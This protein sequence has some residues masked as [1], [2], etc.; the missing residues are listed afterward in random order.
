MYSAKSNQL[1][2]DDGLYA[3]E[4]YYIADYG[5]GGVVKAKEIIIDKIGFNEDSADYLVSQS[6]KFAIWLADSILKKEI[7]SSYGGSYEDKEG[8]FGGGFV[9]IDNN[10][11]AKKSVIEWQKNKPNWIRQRYSQQIRQILD[12]LQHPVTPKQNLR[13]LSFDDALQKSIDWHNELQVLGGDID[14][15]EPENNIILKKYPKNTDGVLYYWVF[16]P[17]N[18]CD[19]ESSRMGHCGRTGYGNNLIS[20]RSVKPY[21]KKH[22]ISDSHVTIAYGINDG[23]FYQVKGKKNQK[24]AE[25]YFPYIFD[26]IKSLLN[27]EINEGFRKEN[28]ESIK[29]VRYLMNEQEKIQEQIITEINFS[30]SSPSSTE[31]KFLKGELN[32]GDFERDFYRYLSSQ[33]PVYDNFRIIHKL[34]EK[35]YVVRNNRDYDELVGEINRLREEAYTYYIENVVDKFKEIIRLSNLQKE[36][37]KVLMYFQF[38]G[39][40]SE[41]GE[42]ED[43]GFGDMTNEEL[44]ELYELKSDMFSDAE[45][46]F[47]IFDAGVINIEELKEI[48]DGN[49]E[50]DTFGNQMKLY[51]RD[52][53]SEAPSTIV[54]INYPCD[55]VHR[56]LDIDR[57]FRDDLVAKILCGDIEEV[58][59]SWS[60]YYEN[61]SDLVDNLNKEN[62]Q[63]II[64]E[65]V[66]ITGLDESVV[67]ENGIEYY[68]NDNDDDFTKDDF[69]NIIRVLASAQNSADS[70]DYF[71]YLY[72][73]IEGALNELGEVE[74]LNDEG[75]KMTIDLSTYM[76]LEE[77]GKNMDYYEL[78]DVE[79]LFNE[80]IGSEIDLPKLRIDDRYSPY[81]SNED[82]NQYLS[83]SD[84]EQGFKQ[85][86][87][88]EN[89]KKDI[90][91]ASKLS[92]DELHDYIQ[93]KYIP[94]VKSADLTFMFTETGFEYD[95]NDSSSSKK[96]IDYYEEQSDF[97]EES[98]N[99]NTNYKVDG[100]EIF[101]KEIDPETDEE[102]DSSEL[103]ELISDNTYNFSYL[104]VADVNW[105]LYYDN[106]YEVYLIIMH[107]HLGGDPRG[108]YGKPFII[109]GDDKDELLSR[110]YSE[111]LSGTIFARIE[112]NDG[113]VIN[114]DST[115]DSQNYK[116]EFDEESSEIDSE[117]SREL[118]NDF[119]S[120]GE[121]K[122]DEFIEIIIDKSK[123]QAFKNYFSRG[124]GV[125]DAPSI[126]VEILGTG[127]G[128]WMSLEGMSDGDEVMTA[129]Q[130]FYDELNEEDGGNREE[131][132]IADMEGFGHDVFYSEYMGESD[133]DDLLE[134]YELFENSDFPYQVV[135]LF[136]NEKGVEIKDAISSMNDAYY[137]AYDN[138][139]D[140]AYQMVDEGVYTPSVNEMY[141]TDIDK[142]IISGEE[143]D[144]RLS[145]M[146]YDDII[147]RAEKESEFE[148]KESNIQDKINVLEDEKE[149]LESSLDLAD[150]DDIDFIQDSLLE[151]Q[152][153]IEEL[154]DELSN[155]KET[156]SDSIKDEVHTILYDE[157]YEQLEND[158]EGFLN[159][160]GYEKPTDASFVSIDY[161]EIADTLKSDYSII[162]YDRKYYIFI[163]Y[164]NGGR[165]KSVGQA[166]DYNYYVVE[167]VSKKIISGH[168]TKKEANEH[169]EELLKNNKK[170]KLVCYPRSTVEIKYNIDTTSK[171]SFT[172][173]ESFKYGGD[174]ALRSNKKES[175]YHLW[176]TKKN[177]SVEKKYE[178]GGDVQYTNFD[179][180]D[181]GYSSE[182]NVDDKSD[183]E[184][185][186][187]SSFDTFEKGGQAEPKLSY[188]D[189]IETLQEYEIEG[190]FGKTLEKG[191]EMYYLPKNSRFLGRK[192]KHIDKKKAYAEYSELYDSFYMENGGHIKPKDKKLI[193]THR[194]LRNVAEPFR[195]S[196]AWAKRQWLEA[197]FGDGTGGAK[198]EGGGEVEFI[199]YNGEEIMYSPHFETY[200][201][202]DSEFKTLEEAKEFIDKGSPTPDWMRE[203]YRRGLYKKGGDIKITKSLEKRI[204]SLNDMIQFAID[205][206]ILGQTDFDSTVD[207]F[208]TFTEPITIKGK[209]VYVKYEDFD[210]KVSER[211]NTNDYSQLDELKWL[212]SKLRLAIKKG[213]K[214]EGLD[215][216]EKFHKGGE[217]EPKLNFG[218]FK[219]TLREY[220]IEGGFGKT[221]E[222]GLEMYYLPNNSK[223]LKRKFK[224]RD[225]RKA[226]KE[227]LELYNS[228][229]ESGGQLGEVSDM[230]P[231]PEPMSIIEPMEKGGSTYAD[232]GEIKK[233]IKDGVLELEY[234]QATDEQVKEYGLKSQKALYLKN[235]CVNE[236]HRLKGVGK[237]ALAYLDNYAKENGY[238]V[239]F[240]YVAQKGIFT[241]DD[242][243]NYFCDVDLIKNWLK[244]NGYAINQD[245]NDFHKVISGSTFAGGGEIKE[246]EDINF[247]DATG[248]YNTGYY[249]LDD[250]GEIMVL[251][252]K[253]K[254]ISI[255][256]GSIKS[257]K[258]DADKRLWNKSFHGHRVEY[259]IPLKWKD[260]LKIMSNWKTDGSYSWKHQINDD[261][262]ILVGYYDAYNDMLYVLDSDIGSFNDPVSP[263]KK[264]SI[265]KFKNWLKDR[266]DVNYAL[267][268]NFNKEDGGSTY[269]G[270]GGVEEN[271]LKD[272]PFIYDVV[273]KTE[274]DV[275]LEIEDFVLKLKILH[276]YIDFDKVYG[277]SNS[278]NTDLYFYKDENQVAE[279]IGEWSDEDESYDSHLYLGREYKG[280]INFHPFDGMGGVL[281]TEFEKQVFNV[282]L[283]S[284][285]KTKVSF[286]VDEFVELLNKDNQFRE[287][288]FEAIFDDEG[289]GKLLFENN[290]FISYNNISTKDSY[291]F[292]NGIISPIISDDFELVNKETLTELIIH[293]I[294]L[295]ISQV[296]EN[297]FDI[298]FLESIGYEFDSDTDLWMEKDR[299]SNIELQ[300]LNNYFYS[301]GGSTYSRGGGTRKY[302]DND[303]RLIDAKYDTKCSETGE[304][305][306]KGEQCVYYPSSKSCFSMNSKQAKEFRDYMS[307]LEMG[308]N[309]SKGGSTYAEGGEIKK[310]YVSDW[311]ASLEQKE[312]FLDYLDMHNET[313]DFEKLKGDDK[314]ELI[315]IDAKNMTKKNIED[316]L[317]YAEDLGLEAFTSYEKRGSTYA[318][319]GKISQ[320]DELLSSTD[321]S[322]KYRR[323]TDIRKKLLHK[324]R[325]SDADVKYLEDNGIDTYRFA[326][327]G[328]TYSDYEGTDAEYISIAKTKGKE[329]VNWDEEIR[330]Y[331]GDKY[332]SLTEDEKDLIV[333]DMMRDYDSLNSF[334]KGGS[335]EEQNKHV[336]ENKTIEIQ[337]HA[338]ELDEVVSKT[339][340]VPAW[341]VSKAT[342]VTTDLSDMT[343]FLDG[344]VKR[345]EKYFDGGTLELPIDKA[346]KIFHLP[347]E[348]SIYVPS[349]KN[350]NETISS[351][352]LQKRVDE[353]KDFVGNLFGGYTSNQ[354][355]GGFVDSQGELVNEDVVKVTSF[356]EK[357]TFEKHKETLLKKLSQWAKDW[358]QEAIGYEFEGD[359]YYVPENYADGGSIYSKGG[360]TFAGGGEIEAYDEEKYS[361]EY[362]YLKKIIT[363]NFGEKNI[364]YSS[365]DWGGLDNWT[366]KGGMYE[367]VFIIID[368]DRKVILMERKY[369]E[370]LDE[371]ED[372]DILYAEVNDKSALQKL[373]NMALQIKHPL[374]NYADGGAIYSKGGSLKRI[375]N[376]PLLKYVIYEDDW[377]INLVKL[378][379]LKS[380]GSKYKSN[381]E[382]GIFRG[383][384]KGE[385]DIWEFNTLSEA[386]N[387]FNE[388]VELSNTYSKIR[389]EGVTENYTELN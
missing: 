76:S 321:D 202:N 354:A 244:D 332:D 331:A 294:A 314:V 215:I 197:D 20:L 326:K 200:Y 64:D 47:A 361:S 107:P 73:S 147:Q 146:S 190:G 327:G 338:E 62:E 1:I 114:F 322:N 40:G 267:H 188:D 292:I 28:E 218:D 266:L 46:I 99:R 328:S 93:E 17:S 191:F 342:R 139:R 27:D 374:N 52:I 262:G 210:K 66:R 55:D 109:Q 90:N 178:Q 336:L 26:L 300:I 211:F 302:Y 42:E 249:N 299:F 387:K 3:S 317:N 160:Y 358:G 214:S 22:T 6:E 352:E 111:F 96:V 343:H 60:Y 368:D 253:L 43:Y 232:G 385:K 225:K 38:N 189:F 209:Y 195:K 204:M 340:E 196:G 129:I 39:F 247:I 335:L 259:H 33:I 18:Y 44:R 320:I 13:N 54:E 323:L 226:Y 156:F 268:Y 82:F 309:Y 351:D 117:L 242:R 185:P 378:N 272:L 236:N 145:D 143:A 238:D 367:G 136:A 58:Y 319:G 172:D 126:Y 2:E 169:K 48:I 274:G 119:E 65:I 348:S 106:E 316:T 363:K 212:L 375:S 118:V 134:A 170:I 229:F 325:L 313:Y 193:T 174:V 366:I 301:K 291:V 115:Q 235:F 339:K 337:H 120:F 227:Y 282:F 205:N 79:D 329:S 63:R 357:D 199:E 16:I 365:A 260:F 167:T 290:E 138:L 296:M 10:K 164:K 303:P 279:F 383:G 155:L 350:V 41:Y 8:T 312:F 182:E 347:L 234:S 149:S 23:V 334:A 256:S 71:K 356:A 223:F 140:F 72:D 24:P 77:I 224:H 240:G 384:N 353:V 372:T 283:K 324:I 194:A 304:P 100:W 362:D 113:S 81:G 95:L 389:N 230:L 74:S 87:K 153:E 176:K 181:S 127:E 245:N 128:K 50:F 257:R 206:E 360:S 370:E 373:F 203:A 241:K 12:W 121:L 250:N 261:N 68:L 78:T 228:M 56:L 21:G 222:K 263:M 157:T 207:T 180:L 19:L 377:Y 192:F 67:K 137:G 220:E 45:S 278:Y 49:Q 286:R 14:F 91:M 105:R 4:Y 29:V 382:F 344:E 51:E 53:I 333:A 345:M 158:L 186:K 108:N 216:P 85:G 237:K 359:L 269:A 376:S 59:D 94:E 34:N 166:K 297:Y 341:V 104:G 252:Y 173:I 198:F 346:K 311:L 280:D 183:S 349:T 275:D 307:D 57:D 308:H 131:Y 61:P 364:N 371:N 98:L 97:N 141:V 254:P 112:L 330:E 388:L 355:I 179:T 101:R 295:D 89:Y 201:V 219:E 284:G 217:I 248:K 88:I 84:L 9:K 243:L 123:E 379:P 7:T 288:F 310:I 151:K 31:Y 130:E 265:S 75:V 92:M 171:K 70:S 163:D 264:E 287:Y 281:M 35:L 15:A 116:F 177:V 208:I 221:L 305:I 69:D 110:F 270:G 125:D 80:V 83:D 175:D 102:Y 251:D 306:K 11:I 184:K 213:A 165:I 239:I 277:Y 289:T 133:F 168:D 30:F 132:R 122:G 142:R 25:K 258:E 124:G 285:I 103:E 135:I 293:K 318:E 231:S 246:G 162:D 381:S 380:N 369:N 32:R 152:E 144:N 86:G 298:D 255:K 154:E 148:E 276:E 150:S 161:D 233:W 5:S 36:S 159:E 271:A 37:E 386:E 187:Y 273:F 315:V